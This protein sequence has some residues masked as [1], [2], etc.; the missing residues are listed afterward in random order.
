MS[1]VRVEYVNGRL[2]AHGGWR[3]RCRRQSARALDAFADAD[4]LDR[5]PTQRQ[6]SLGTP[7]P[8]PNRFTTAPDSRRQ[9][10]EVPR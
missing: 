6:G 1:Q 7:S 10:L 4:V 2:V 3:S 9:R 5:G 8:D